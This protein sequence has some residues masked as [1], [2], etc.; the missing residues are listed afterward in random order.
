MTLRTFGP[1]HLAIV[2]AVLLV[3]AALALAARRWPGAARP[4]RLALAAA[5]AF[6]ELAW[7]AYSIAHGWV[8]PPHGLPLDLCDVV[9]WLTVLVLV[10]PMPWALETVYFLGL[11]GSG[12]AVLTPDVGGVPF[13]SYSAVKF[14]VAH[15]GVVASVLFLVWSGALRPRPGSWWRVFLLVNAYAACIAVFDVLTGTN[16]MYLREKPRSGS[17]LDLLGPW[18]WYVLGGEAVALLLLWMLSL[19]FRRRA[20]SPRP[21]TSAEL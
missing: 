17:L 5:I 12:M 6:D 21:T 19:P 11:A 16:Y 2:A 7:Y 9:L 1:A 8:D 13:P 18:P 20:T 10:R 3:A 4:I 14:F 15:G